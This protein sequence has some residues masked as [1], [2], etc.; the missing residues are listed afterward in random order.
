MERQWRFRQPPN[1]PGHLLSAAGHDPIIAAY[2]LD[3]GLTTPEAARHYLEPD[4]NNL[5]DPFEFPDMPKAVSRIQKALAEGEFIGIWGD[6]DV[7]GQTSTALL[8]DCLE[9]L[10]AS[11]RYHLPIRGK[12][13]HGISL[14]SLQS[15]MGT[16]IQMLITCDTGISEHTS[17]QYAAQ[18]GLDVIITDHH[19][20]PSE[21]PLAYACINP[22]LLP[23]GHAFETLSGSGVAFEL[24]LAVCRNQTRED[25]ALSCLDLAAIGLIADMA[26][27]KRDARLIAQLGLKLL[28][29][30]PR[31]WLKILLEAAQMT[32]TEVDES[33]IGFTIAPRLNAVGRLEDAN[34]LVEFLLDRKPDSLQD[35]AN[36]LE[37]LNA[38]RKWLCDQVF[39]SAKEQLERQRELS[40]S[41][42]IILSNPTWPGGVLGLAAGKLKEKFYRPVILL[43]DSGDGVLRGSAR[44]VEG[45]NITE[46]ISSASSLLLGFGGHAMA[47]GLSLP[48][49]KL[50]E[51]RNEI[52]TWLRL[53]GL[54]A[55]EPPALDIDA[56]L[57]LEQINP[58][59]FQTMQKLAPFG[60]GNP[61]LVFCCRRLKITS[62]RP[63]DRNREHFK[64]QIQDEQGD[65][66]PFYWW[67]I[68]ETLIP[69]GSFDLSFSL[70]KNSYKGETTLQAEYID[71]HPV[72]EPETT[73]PGEKNLEI[74]DLRLLTQPL[75]D[76]MR[77]SSGK[78]YLKFEE[79]PVLD[80]P[81]SV[82]R[83][84]LYSV[85]NL[86]L[87]SIPPSRE[88]MDE[89]LTQASPN[90]LILAFPPPKLLNISQFL[91]R[92]AGLIKFALQNHDGLTSTLDLA[93]AMNQNEG[94]I[95]A[96]I[97]WFQAEG[98]ILVTAADLGLIR[99]KRSGTSGNS[100]YKGAFEKQINFHLQETY[101]YQKFFYDQSISVLKNMI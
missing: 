58:Q 44:S 37:A 27:L 29:D 41:A 67:N 7:D 66:L 72:E 57:K 31:Q 96:G 32:T 77:V 3:R 84:Q 6:F 97:A 20:L 53:R 76:A 87:A 99:I 98:K 34:P 51:F 64:F 86:I 69:T 49:E 46:A 56:E 8:V 59:F 15:F 52:N 23:E 80:D 33:T 35:M 48:A 47:A 101:S 65:S 79:P 63:L 100:K 61:P 45:V 94:A 9:K 38:N 39:Q 30:Q 50:P 89:I 68:D 25:I 17:L 70:R 21:L 85:T 82:G 93:R 22:H 54:A 2:L 95:E 18:N 78:S 24:M 26:P 5:T 28:T 36:H 91:N 90:C 19:S 13:S 42:I 11:I 83:N 16:G 92:L 14:P 10:G 81:F 75:E 40:T 88:K 4:I 43:N 71:I 62:A 73:I 1:L 74:L 55:A 12:E 60:M